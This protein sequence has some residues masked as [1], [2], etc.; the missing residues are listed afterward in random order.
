LAV[1]AAA[2]DRRDLLGHLGGAIYSLLAAMP[3][4]LLRSLVLYEPPLY[5]DPVDSIVVDDAQAALDTGTRTGPWRSPSPRS[6]SSMQRYRC[7]GRWSRCGKGS[8]H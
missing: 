7:S 6:A 4:P 1:L 5:F 2:G 3:G 8:E